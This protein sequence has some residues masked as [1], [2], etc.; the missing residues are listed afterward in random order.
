MAEHLELFEVV[1]KKIAV[2]F[3]E[4]GNIIH[5]CCQEM[6]K[7]QFNSS[8]KPISNDLQ[9]DIIEGLIDKNSIFFNQ[10]SNAA[11]LV[12]QPK[13]EQQTNRNEKSHDTSLI[14]RKRRKVE[15]AKIKRPMTPF[16]AYF[17]EQKPKIM[18]EFPDLPMGKWAQKIS[19]KWKKLSD[20]D[21]KK[22]RD[23][24]DELFKEYKRLCTDTKDKKE[25]K[26][27][28]NNS[29]DEKKEKKIRT[30]KKKTCDSYEK[31]K[32]MSRK[33]RQEKVKKILSELNTTEESISS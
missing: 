5:N 33:E 10:I 11:K 14:K 7:L 31:R 3:N 23:E 20:E 30:T 26:E 2:W 22:Y 28:L 25:I 24:F 8:A 29:D 18:M 27:E 6:S 17:N 15:K 32:V 13:K 4:L 12:K 19:E 9:N 21:K 16:I 1:S